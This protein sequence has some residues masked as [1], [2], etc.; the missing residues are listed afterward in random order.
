MHALTPPLT[1]CLGHQYKSSRLF[2]SRRTRKPHA[3]CCLDLCSF[4]THRALPYASLYGSGHITWALLLDNVNWCEA[5]QLHRPTH[6]KAG[7]PWLKE[8]HS[9][10]CHTA[11]SARHGL[12][13]QQV[14][15]MCQPVIIPAAPWL[16]VQLR[17]RTNERLY[18]DPRCAAEHEAQLSVRGL[19]RLGRSMPVMAVVPSRIDWQSVRRQQ[20]RR[21][22]HTLAPW[23]L[24]PLRCS[25]CRTNARLMTTYLVRSRDS[26]MHSHA[27]CFDFI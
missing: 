1:P 11:R 22:D 19:R 6:T 20:N 15:G 21:L 13:L 12:L 24:V 25:A 9:E 5:G 23:L 14:S 10:G 27:G 4:M 8:Q 26:F 18:R 3:S 2:P 17:I 16:L 7:S